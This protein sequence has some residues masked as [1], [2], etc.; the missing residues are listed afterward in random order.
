[1]MAQEAVASEV[2]AARRGDRDAFARLVDSYRNVVCSITLAI[3]RDLEASEDLAQEV[4]LAAWIGLGQLRS[5]Q[6]FLPWIRQLARN[7][8][9]EF[10][11]SRVR[12]RRGHA[13]WQEVIESGGGMT[14]TSE[15]IIVAEEA[16]ALAQAMDQLPAE[17]R[18]IVTLYYREGSSAR[19]VA[20]LLG[21]S[22]DAIK[23]R[24]ER[25]RAAL[26]E[27]V[28]ARFDDAVRKTAPGA[29]F[30]AAVSLALAAGAP[31][32]ASAAALGL[33]GAG[34]G[35]KLLGMLAGL[36]G[37][38]AGLGGG[39]FGIWFGLRLEQ[40]KALDEEERRQLTRLG[41]RASALTVLAVGGMSAAGPLA[42]RGH[43]GVG[44]AIMLACYLVFVAGLAWL[45]GR[46]LPRI[47]AR[48]LAAERA[49][50]PGA[51]RRQRR[52]ARLRLAGGLFGLLCG[53]AGAL[54]GCW[55]LL[56]G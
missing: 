48:R 20:S 33:G 6:S 7:K 5:P 10:V 3:S 35:G 14:P 44:A 51:E 19:Q 1:M 49:R 30:T 26:R 25:A 53:M 13:G 46:Q 8:A 24:L 4:F 41:V 23:K 39:L 47:M 40:R 17:T 11:R 50:D 43:P 54:L 37:A 29:A 52:N 16:L 12:G 27:A 28:L 31:T 18:E 34:T 42:S 45:Y 9:H 55:F 15:Q 38:L 22:E 2:L 36:S 21:L 56:R 32:T